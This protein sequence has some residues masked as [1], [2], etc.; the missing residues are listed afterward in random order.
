VRVRRLRCKSHHPRP[1][2]SAPGTASSEGAPRLARSAQ[3]RCAASIE[4]TGARPSTKRSRRRRTRTSQREPQN[5]DACGRHR[6]RQGVLRALS[7]AKALR[8]LFAT[9]HSS[10]VTSNGEVEG[11]DDHAGQAPR[12][13]TVFQ[14]PRRGTTERSR[15]P[16]TIV[17]RLQ[18]T[19][20]AKYPVC[21]RAYRAHLHRGTSR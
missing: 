14:R 9:P 4:T 2:L 3:A 6:V 13:H 20:H 16:P 11:P 10:K 19:V 18:G 21:P 1:L 5:E 8:K 7:S 17:R 12:A 15:S